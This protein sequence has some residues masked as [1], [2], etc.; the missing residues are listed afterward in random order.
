MNVTKV[1]T[2]QYP[3]EE[4][5]DWA[6]YTAKL[7]QWV[8]AAAKEG[9]RLLIFPE[10][11]SMELVSLFDDEIRG[12]LRGQLEAMQGLHEKFLD[13][14]AELARECEVYILAG[15]FP[16]RIPGGAFRNRAYFFSP[17]GSMDYQDKMMMTR[18]EAEDWLIEPGD[19]LRVFPTSM[20]TVG[21]AICYDS[22]FPLLARS[23]VES[24]AEILVVPSCTDTVHGYHRVR[25][26]CQA[27]A[28]ESQCYVVHSALV[29]EVDWSAAIDSNVG[30]AAVYSPVDKGFPEDGVVS[31]GDWNQ[32][33]WVYGEIDLS[34]LA[35]VRMDG[36]V[37]NHRDWPSSAVQVE[38]ET[39]FQLKKEKVLSLQTSS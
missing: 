19:Q 18:F 15:S 28:L 14:H 3:V 36:S 27:R 7:K 31:I 6:V 23:Q 34:K 21:I 29:G 8:R 32:P 17:D 4:L 5:A 24:G 37:L 16:V 9:A 22:E 11:A 33:R 39:E 13:L 38:G 10:Y 25:I 30:R 35:R 2:A 1:A 12:D 26:G 20:G